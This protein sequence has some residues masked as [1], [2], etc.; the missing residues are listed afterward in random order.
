MGPLAGIK[1]IEIASIG[2]GPFAAMMLSDMGAE[3]IRIERA[4]GGALPMPTRDLMTR[5]RARIALDLKD[6][7]GVAFVIELCAGAD[8]LIEGFRPG[9]MERLGLGPNECSAANAK[10]V[11]GRMTG[12]GQTGPLAQR[13]GHDIDYVALSGAL[14]AI[15]R[16]GDGPLPPLNLIGDFGGGG[17]LLAFGMVCAL[18]EARGSG[19]GQVVDAAMVDGA[20]L[21]M[22]MFHGLHASGAHSLA[23][24][25]NLLDSGAPFYDTYQTADG[26]YIAV[27]ALEPAFYAELLRALGLD[28]RALPP[29]Y[30]RAGWPAMK[31]RFSEI[32]RQKSRAEWSAIFEPLDACVAPVLDLVEARSHPHLVERASFIARDGVTQPAPAPRFSRSEARVRDAPLDPITAAIRFGVSSATIDRLRAAA[33]LSEPT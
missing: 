1:L 32:F 18:L 23:R 14:H 10:L 19:K 28:A 27:G 2:P 16:A 29:Q 22:T 24:G 31:Q 26:E 25:Q 20:S 30:D 5:G 9:V 4:T 8:G 3:V 15:G 17:M 11:Y 6:E 13:A 21:L 12:Y 7:R 33:V